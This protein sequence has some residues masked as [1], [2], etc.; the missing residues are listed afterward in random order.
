MLKDLAMSICGRSKDCFGAGC[1]RRGSFF[2]DGSI[3][4]RSVQYGRNF[5]QDANINIIHAF[6]SSSENDLSLTRNIER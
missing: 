6:D 3:R 2:A 4:N 1:Q 5:G